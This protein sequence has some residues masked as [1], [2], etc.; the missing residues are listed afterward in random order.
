MNLYDKLLLWTCFCTFLGSFM[1][2][3]GISGSTN[4]WSWLHKWWWLAV[5]I[6]AASGAGFVLGNYDHF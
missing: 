1:T 5:A 4:N 2:L 3:V 6:G